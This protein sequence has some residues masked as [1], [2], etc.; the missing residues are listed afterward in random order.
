[1]S[2]A[3]VSRVLNGKLVVGE[4]LDK[5]IKQTVREIGYAPNLAARGLNG[6]Q[7]RLI[8]VFGSRY[9]SFA[10]GISEL[11]ITGL[12]N[13]LQP[14]KFEVFYRLLR[15]Q[16]EDSVALPYWKFDGAVVLQ[17]TDE[18]VVE[19]LRDRDVP[20]VALNEIVEG[21]A[22]TVLADDAG[23]ADL[24][25]DHLR[26]LG[27]RN[28]AYAGAGANYVPHYSIAERR[29]RVKTGTAARKMNLVVDI[30][31]PSVWENATGF[32]EHVLQ[33][34][35]TAV[36]AY[37]HQEAMLLMGAAY[38]MHVRVPDQLSLLCFND[39]F[40]LDILPPPMTA[41]RVDGGRM[42]QVGAQLLLDVL[43]GGDTE[44]APTIRVDEELVVRQSTAPPLA[45]RPARQPSPA[46]T[47]VQPLEQ[48][49]S[50]R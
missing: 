2:H 21:A 49:D 24:A 5:R 47:A 44:A 50:E 48:R 8:G 11:L 22:A 39:I 29:D 46:G 40:P 27:H 13:V 17:G 30:E 38:S 7:D 9:T 31:C 16:G 42:G 18:T 19:A 45:S 10:K 41:V 28:I 4:E 34:G 25:L 35:A 43:Q 37:D 20:F 6:K 14:A 26:D 32:L 12:V 33:E 36:L 1:M 23:G 15:P 3:T